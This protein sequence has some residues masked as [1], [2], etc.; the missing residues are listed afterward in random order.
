M[1]ALFLST[2]DFVR[3]QV[4]TRV[5]VVMLVVIPVL[6]VLLASSVLGEFS[7]SLGGSASGKSATAL[8]AGWAAGFLG[9]ILGFFQVS[10]SRDT[11]RRLALAG[12]G[13]VRTSLSRIGACIVLALL[14]AVVAFA[15]LWIKTGLDQPGPV[16]AAILF[17][18]LIYVGIGAFVG[19]L[20]RDELAGSMIVAL[21]W[22]MDMYGGPG[23]SGSGGGG[24]LTPTRKSS[25]VLMAAAG[26]Q[27]SSAGDWAIA[28]ATALGALVI[29]FLA[30]WFSSRSRTRGH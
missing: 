7:K 16:F 13:G 3:Q 6:F 15:T 26:G 25:E 17:C 30:F 23:M 1:G 14:V 4:R 22:L 18:G 11:D 10:A 2:S 5:T 28:G 9:G 20:V 12:M 27:S 24:H 21:I 8:G 19:S 29:A